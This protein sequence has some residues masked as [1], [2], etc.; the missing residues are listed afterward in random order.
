[1]LQFEDS[2]RRWDDSRNKHDKSPSGSAPPPKKDKGCAKTFAL[3]VISGVHI[4][5]SQCSFPGVRGAHK[6]GER[7]EK[8]GHGGYLNGYWNC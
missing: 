7:S 4:M 2:R 1:M 5:G 8:N 3:L 6:R